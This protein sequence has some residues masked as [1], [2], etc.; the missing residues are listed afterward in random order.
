VAKAYGA[1]TCEIVVWVMDDLH[2]DADDF[3]DPD[4]CRSAEFRYDGGSWWAVGEEESCW[5]E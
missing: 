1:K 2:P 5:S 3:E 4:A